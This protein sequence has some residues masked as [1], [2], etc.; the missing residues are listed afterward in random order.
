MNLGTGNSNRRGVLCETSSELL[1]KPAVS[2]QPY[3]CP[4][5]RL[6]KWE[7]AGPLAA[8][9]AAAEAVVVVDRASEEAE[10]AAAAEAGTAAELRT[11]DKAASPLSNFPTASRVARSSAASIMSARVGPAPM[12]SF[13]HLTSSP[14]PTSI[15]S[16][17][18]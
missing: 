16:P 5:Q 12:E 14:E 10:D 3:F 18:G 17:K 9:E 15:P 1:Q 13:R 11:S 2:P 8:V 4:P 6:L 7:E